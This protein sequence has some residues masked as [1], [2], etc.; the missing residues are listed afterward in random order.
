MFILPCF[1]MG[2]GR[3]LG[4]YVKHLMPVSRLSILTVFHHHPRTYTCRAVVQT[5][6]N[7]EPGVA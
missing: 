6:E 7:S 5:V 1:L 4:F 3:L 2:D